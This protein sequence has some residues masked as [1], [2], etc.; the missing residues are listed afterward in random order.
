[1]TPTP[2]SNPSIPVPYLAGT[3]SLTANAVAN[4]LTLIQAQLA[5]NCP[6]S[7]VELLISPDAA[8]TGAV[9]VGAYSQIAGALSATNY[10]YSLAATSA[11]RLY[12]A[13]YPGNTISLGDIQV[14]SAAAAKL[15]VEILP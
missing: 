6:G 10:G 15:H 13:T 9:L 11:P 8:N 1:M 5:T 2:S 3:L 14:L 4:L 12:Q 7:V